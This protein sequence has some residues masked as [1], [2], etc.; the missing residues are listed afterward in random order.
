[1]GYINSTRDWKEHNQKLANNRDYSKTNWN[2][3]DI[4]RYQTRTSFKK[5][6]PRTIELS[7]KGAATIKKFS[8]QKKENINKKISKAMSANNP[9]R[10]RMWVFRA[11]ESLCILKSEYAEYKNIG[12]LSA[13]DKRDI[14]KS[15]LSTRWMNDGTK[16]RIVGSAEIAY[17]VSIGYVFGRINRKN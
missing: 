2:K 14:K 7:K 9:M 17:F 15:K 3:N 6:C 11:E 4:K 16:N 8:A 10:K 13:K 5:G 12:W 1:M